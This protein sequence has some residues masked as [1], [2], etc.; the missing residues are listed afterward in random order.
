MLYL[1]VV[2]LL[3]AFSFGLIK[4]YLAGVDSAFVTTI[5]LGLSL[6]VFLPFLRLRGVSVRIGLTLAA[7][8]AVQFGVMYLAY[9][10]SFRYLHAYEAALFTITTPVFVTLLVDCFEHALRPRA[11]IA[12]LLAVVGT[13]IIVVKSTD[14]KLTLA[15]L[16]LV[17]LS[18]VAFAFGQVFYRRLRKQH[19]A[20]KDREIFA[21]L[22][23]GAVVV[24][25]AALIGRGVSF[26]L[27]ASQ[28]W[29]LVYLGIVA[30][31]IGFFLWNKGAV[32][33]KGG[34]LAVMNNL[35]VPL[36]VAC[37]LLFFGESA[38]LPRL[39]A[40]LLVLGAAVWLAEKN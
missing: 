24:A 31:G 38:N 23:A 22:Y 17:Q 9:I 2:S 16:A 37:A 6:I 15:G 33:V 21:L 19:A 39:V 29:T 13:G 25:V 26:N 18:N 1:I 8:G 27:T 34:T 20:F 3:W 10:E 35:K 32:Q 40:S 12:A 28:L 14:L 7:I 5:R 30:S 11:L 36:A 4:R